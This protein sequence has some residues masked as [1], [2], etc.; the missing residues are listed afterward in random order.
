MPE[1]RSHSDRPRHHRPTGRIATPSPAFPGKCHRFLLC[2]PLCPKRYRLRHPCQVRRPRQLRPPQPRRRKPPGVFRCRTSNFSRKA[3]LRSHR[4]LQDHPKRSLP[5]SLPQPCGLQGQ[6]SAPIQASHH[7]MIRKQASQCGFSHPRP[8]SQ[9]FLKCRGELFQNW[10]RLSLGFPPKWNPTP[11]DR[12]AP[13]SRGP[14][15][16]LWQR[17]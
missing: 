15:P 7:P 1:A 8:Q 2:L 16:C 11:R 9:A 3:S 10:Q 13:P 12:Q 5:N 17:F 4:W 14:F 6:T